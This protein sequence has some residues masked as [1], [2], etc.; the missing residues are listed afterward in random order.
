MATNAPATLVL[1]EANA[2][3]KAPP[4]ARSA[5]SGLVRAQ[6]RCNCAVLGYDP[7]LL[8][9]KKIGLL[10]LA[11]F[12][13]LLAPLPLSAQADDPSETFLKAY[14]TSQQGEKLEHEN[15]FKAALSKFRSAGSLLEDLR[16]SHSD[17]QP[18]IVEYRARKIGESILR[19]Q[20]KIGTQADLTAATEPTPV[21]TAA[22][23]AAA[24]STAPPAATP[25]DAVIRK[26]TRELQEKVDQLQSELQKSRGQ[27]TSVQKEKDSLNGRLQETNSKLEKAQSELQRTQGA[28]KAVRDQ[29]VQAQDSLKKIQESGKA[30]SKAVAPL[31]AEIT[32]LKEALASAEKGRAAAEKEKEVAS[33]KLS[34]AD[35]Q[36]ASV[37]KE[38]DQ[39][40]AELKVS[41]Q[42][43]ERVEV[44][45]A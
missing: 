1:R 15:Q 21:P 27:Y 28:E 43:Q 44:L 34:E 20:G 16:K 31:R 42:A 19:V 8:R 23:I 4:M 36:I 35:A 9:M 24:T 17:W 39:L 40:V 14:M 6:Q 3:A 5:L 37:T 33:T 30:D 11:G 41:K 12:S 45:V 22:P 25:S 7:L 29:L 13:L 10:L 18:A 38:R 32:K 26:A 2:K